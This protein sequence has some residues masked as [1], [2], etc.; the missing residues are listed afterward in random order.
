M[1][2]SRGP[3]LASQCSPPALVL[4]SWVV[5]TQLG[6]HPAGAPAHSPVGEGNV[7]GPG[8][9]RTSQAALVWEAELA[10]SSARTMA[11]RTMAATKAAT[12]AVAAVVQD[13]LEAATTACPS[14]DRRTA[15]GVHASGRRAGRVNFRSRRTRPAGQ[16][17]RTRP[18]IFA[19]PPPCCSY[20]APHAN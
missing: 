11:V 4:S 9:R 7:C 10:A 15:L 18:P 12:P 17:R 16:Q 3:A 19:S 8:A 5:R 1:H 13:A 20:E 6:S 2:A 14:P